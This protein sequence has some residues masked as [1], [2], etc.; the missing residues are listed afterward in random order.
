MPS[1]PVTLLGLGAMGRALAAALLADGH[2][3]TV[4]NRTPGRA[5]DLPGAVVAPALADALAAPGPIL[6]CLLDHASVHDTL[7]P[8][9]ADLSG[10]TLINLTSTTPDEARE[11]AAWAA[12]HGVAYLDG[13]IMA[14]PQMIGAPGASILYSGSA[15]IFDDHRGLLET[16][17][18]AEYFGDD[19]GLASLYDFALLS[20]MYL[21]F[22]G[23]AHGAALVGSAGVSATEFAARATPWVRAMAA[24]FAGHAAFIDSGDYRADTQ[25]LAF[26]K[27]ALD[28]LVR[29]SRAAGVPLTVLGPVKALLD[30]QVADGHGGESFARIFEGLRAG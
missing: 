19:A 28:A 10:R 1:T 7:D 12:A 26:N 11:L 21:M 5:A 30:A 15:A 23:F 13:G 25:S 2:P 4:W 16:F 22:A 9:A 24:G 6:A 3:V 18:A 17:G 29:A 27:A 20:G 8:V 14:V